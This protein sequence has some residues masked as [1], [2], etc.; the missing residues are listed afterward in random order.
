MVNALRTNECLRRSVGIN[1]VT[2]VPKVMA[3]LRARRL[4]PE[5]HGAAY[6]ARSRGDLV[7]RLQLGTHGRFRTSAL[8]WGSDSGAPGCERRLN[9]AAGCGVRGLLVPPEPCPHSVHAPRPELESR[10]ERLR[11]RSAYGAAGSK[12]RWRLPTGYPK[13]PTVSRQTSQQAGNPAPPMD[14][15]AGDGSVVALCHHRVVEPGS[16][17][18]SPVPSPCERPA[19]GRLSILPP[20]CSDHLTSLF[21]LI[22]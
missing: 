3:R 18:L 22:R 19:M 15:A 7:A 14:A 12:P 2:T 8:A 6:R 9:P 21:V 13:R 17:S 4:K 20:G 16:T 1:A 11:D 10:C 5:L